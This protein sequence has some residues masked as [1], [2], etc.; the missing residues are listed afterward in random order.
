MGLPV[1]VLGFSGSGKTT[2][3]RNFSTDGLA[4]VNVNG[5]YL[6]FRG[7][8]SEQIVSDNTVEIQRFIKSA[9]AKAIAVDD[10]QYIMVNEF[11]RRAKETGYQKFTDIGKNFWDLVS[12]VRTLP[13]DVIVYFLNHIETGDDG[14]Q[15]VKT[16][17]KLL[18]EK[19][20]IEGMFTIV[21]KTVVE[22]GKYYF[23]TQT[24]GADPCKSPMGLFEN[25]FIQNDLKMVDEAIRTYYS[26]IPE[27]FCADCGRTIM[28][29]S[30]LSVADIVKIGTEKFGRV[31]CNSCA[32]KAAENAE[33]PV[34]AVS[35]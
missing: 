34:E 7:R 5:K 19:T 20:N 11:M 12:F 8:F 28:P 21:L 22:D 2:S 31:L 24:D 4:L 25:M 1:L 3:L 23:A 29:T 17:G 26:L 15:K 27:Q 16:V 6:P 35:E 10:S 32:R 18:D 13:E 14:R 33:K 9:K 30:R